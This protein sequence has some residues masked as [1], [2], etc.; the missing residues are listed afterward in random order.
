MYLL[1]LSMKYNWA[2]Q[3]AGQKSKRDD[4]HNILFLI[5]VCVLIIWE[6]C[7]PNI[8]FENEFITEYI[9]WV[10]SLEE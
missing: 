10:H 7:F 8:N 4:L 9:I 5:E 2:S 6:T 1:Q 3:Q